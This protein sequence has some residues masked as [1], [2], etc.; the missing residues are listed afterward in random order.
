[1]SLVDLLLGKPLATQEEA[2]QR[3]G[4]LAGIP[5]L[6]LDA[7]S[8]A[9]YGPEAA[10]T[11]LIP[12]GT[13]GL[14]YIGP[15]LIVIIAL[16]A[17]VYLSYRQTIAA[18][19]QGGGSY[20]VAGKNLGTNAGLLAAAAL[21]LDYVLVV[22]V[23]ISAGVGALVSALPF[24]H[25]HILALCLTILGFMTLVNLRGVR[26]SGLVFIVPT[27]LFVGC[28]LSILAIGIVKTIASRG[29]PLPVVPPP[30]LP[31]ATTAASL[32]LLLR[33]F[34][35][36]CTAMT[37]VEA[38][39]NGVTV[40]RPPSTVHAQ[41]TLAVII[42]ILGVLL[43]GIAFLVQVYGI[44]ATEPGQPGYE[45]VLSQLV[46]AVVGKSVFYY[47]TI[48]AILAV[49]A[50]S[51]NTAFAGFPRLCRVIAQDDFL[52]H[53]FAVR[54]RRLVFSE[55]IFVLTLLAGILLIVFEGITDRLIPL[56]A[57]GAFSAFTL[58]Q[59]GMV[60]HW[61][62]TGGPQAR[63]NMWING[64]GAAAT[65]IT[66]AVVLVAKFTAGAWITLLLIPAILFIFA[67]VRRHYGSVER[68][69]A[70]TLPL[71][72][73]NLRPPLVVVSVREWDT[74]AHKGLRFALKLSPEVYAVQISRD[75][76][77]DDL[78]A[79]WAEYVEK[80]C[81]AA[82]LPTPKL[83]VLPSPYRRLFGP[84][85]T[86]IM[87][88]KEE[89]PDR[90]IAVIIPELVER[91]WYHYLLHNQQGELLKM[92]LLLRGDQRIVIINV[93]WYLTK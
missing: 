15:I 53:G 7:L 67:S 37:G 66:L 72:V 48:G 86:Y 33:A 87:R 44:G 78:Y 36:G 21:M 52:P 61:R 26:E 23:G 77:M 28:L 4:S 34:A 83:V 54:G 49:L 91:H 57:I 3:I 25:Q 70:R 47:V 45:S 64:I 51:A 18:Y 71:D 41:R 38:V 93:P 9:A 35:S 60:A 5:L 75:D 31:A 14:I 13:L 84:L 62:R 69:M 22:A 88:L 1:M 8:S 39:S 32:W 92:R 27:Y 63:R 20:T 56:F 85:Y 43:A 89:Q 55:G 12:L 40:F 24:L 2:E 6:G 46:A 29:Q 59:A 68:E 65:A 19:P 58:S 80:P 76:K 50:F 42:A 79:H 74:L 16:L 11:V 10:L 81:R 73:T 82:G 90:Q 17:I 30:A